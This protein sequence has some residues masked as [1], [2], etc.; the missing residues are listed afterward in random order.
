M[1]QN[2]PTAYVQFWSGAVDYQ[3]MKNSVLSVEYTGSRGTHEY[4]ISNLNAAGYGSTFLGDARITNRLNY[5]Y[6]DITY[7]GSEG[8]NCYNGAEREVPEQ[9]PL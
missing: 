6:S 8:F 7:R 5:Q 3:V 1:Q 9:Q 4:D 2:I